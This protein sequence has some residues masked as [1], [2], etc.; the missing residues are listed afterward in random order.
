ME[1]DTDGKEKELKSPTSFTLTPITVFF[2][3]NV[4]VVGLL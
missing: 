4:N 2:Y 3:V 1:K